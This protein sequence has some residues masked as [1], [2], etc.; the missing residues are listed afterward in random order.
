MWL[1]FG[2]RQRSRINRLRRKCVIDERPIQ[3]KVQN[4][5]VWKFLFIWLDVVGV[6]IE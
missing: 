1:C 4:I 6:L 3:E 2:Y 5:A